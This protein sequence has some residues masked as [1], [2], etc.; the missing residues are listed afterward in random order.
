[1]LLQFKQGFGKI[2]TQETVGINEDNPIGDEDAK[3]QRIGEEENKTSFGGGLMVE[4]WWCR[5]KH[6]RMN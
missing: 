4:V 2:A 6:A 3:T 1:M 5:E